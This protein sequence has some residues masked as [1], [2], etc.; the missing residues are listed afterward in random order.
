MSLSSD[1]VFNEPCSLVKRPELIKGF[2]EL[3]VW[4]DYFHFI[5]ILESLLL[6]SW[7]LLGVV[8][9]TIFVEKRV[10]VWQVRIFVIV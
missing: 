2:D 3:H 8:I 5:I 9:Q 1:P 6:Q 10:D 7:T 4:F